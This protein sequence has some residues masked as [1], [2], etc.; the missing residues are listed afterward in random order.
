MRFHDAAWTAF[1]TGGF[2]TRFSGEL[3]R[4]LKEVYACCS[5]LNDF[6][7]RHEEITFNP[8]NLPKES[9]NEMRVNNLEVMQKEL[10]K[11][12]TFLQAAK[13]RLEEDF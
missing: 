7:R 12:G 5:I 6:S 11:L 9:I 4:N 2:L 10:D 8:P 1:K 3:N 13:K